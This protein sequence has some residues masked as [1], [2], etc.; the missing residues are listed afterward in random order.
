MAPKAI[1]R[2]LYLKDVPFAICNILKQEMLSVGGEVAVSK[3]II[4]G[5]D[6]KSDCL[7]IGSLAQV[8]ELIFKL[9]RQPPLFSE[10]SSRLEKLI[11]NFQKINLE[12]R[13]RNFKLNLNKRTYIMGVLNITPDSFSNGGQFFKKEEAYRR[14]LQLEEEGADIIDIGGQST[15]PGAKEISPEEEIR[16]VLPVIKRLRRKVKIPIS[17]DT[18]KYKVAKVAL[19]EGVS[20][21]NDIYGFRKDAR[22]A[23]LAN[24]FKAGVVLMHIKGSPPSMQKNPYYKDLIGEIIA[25]LK[26]SVDIALKAGIS[27]KSIMVDPGLGFGKT[28]EHNLFIIKHLSSLKSLGFPILIGPSRKSFIGKILKAPLD[29]RLYGTI[30]SVCISILMGANVVRVHD[31]ACIK[32]AA[33]IADEI[34]RSRLDA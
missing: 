1:S 25:T 26:K 19:A 28:V 13:C 10:F 16:R 15:R 3:G 34:L 2:V 12:F 29:K 33:G 30:A 22:L 32:Q 8:K 11:Q 24:K 5:K 7:V 31:V 21:L 6:K 17:I 14:A 23:K 9:K 20:I 18:Y 27:E 4:S